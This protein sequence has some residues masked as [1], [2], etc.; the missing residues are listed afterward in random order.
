MVGALFA[1]PIGDRLGRRLASNTIFG[2]ASLL[3]ATAGSIG[4][5]SLW[6]FFPGSASAV[7]FPGQPR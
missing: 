3:S 4:S 1:G 2:V 7:D 5:L 6:R